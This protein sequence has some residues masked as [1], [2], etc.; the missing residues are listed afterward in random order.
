MGSTEKKWLVK[1]N[2]LINGPFE[3]NEVVENI[4][5]GDVHLLDEIKGPFERW[6]P[7]RDHSLFAAAIERL[8]A[9][10]YSRREVTITETVDLGTHAAD[11]TQ[12]STETHGD[13][14]TQTLT[15][16]GAGTMTTPASSINNRAK[17]QSTDVDVNIRN[18]IQAPRPIVK[19]QKSRF[20]LV[21]IATFMIIIIAAGAVLLNDF[22]QTKRVEVNTSNFD[23]YTDQGLIH[24]KVGQYREALSFFTKAYEIS[25]NDPNLILEMSPLLVQ[26]DGQFGQV[27]VMIENLLATQYQKEFMKRGKNI[28]GMSLS[29][30]G[31]YE[32]AIGEYDKSLNIDDQYYSALVNKGFALLKIGKG[33]DALPVLQKAIQVSPREA[34]ARYLLTRGLIQEGF[35]TKN[36]QYFSEALSTSNGHEQNFTDFRQEVLFL[37]AVAKMEIGVSKVDLAAAVRRFLSVDT[38]L[39]SLHVHN[40]EHDFQS[41]SWHDYSELC[42]G[43]AQ[44]LDQYTG[45]MLLGFCQ[46]KMDDVVAAK[47]TFEP[48]LS[49]KK[50]D[51]G[52][53]ALYVSS[54]FLLEDTA[55]AKNTINFVSKVDRVKPLVQSLVRGCLTFG[56]IEC[57]ES[58]MKSPYASKL[59]LLYS[60]WSLAEINIS[61]DKVKAKASV[62]QG[63]NIS[64]TFSPLL[65]LSREL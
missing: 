19:K 26:F 34:L 38:E 39:T 9:T 61:K 54:L 41:F 5:K 29:Y 18:N 11:L 44:K 15:E 52:L 36:K 10:T 12:T 47:S 7:I 58:I 43:L 16:T 59:S 42:K 23:D 56:D 3:F 37:A 17:S 1:S 13:D 14:S 33:K 28:V 40:V 48:L 57:V 53:Q 65:K 63:L 24:L 49:Q 64:P 4:F 21:F 45:S 32:D 50:S 60:H 51:G 25:P 27:Q 6:R 55:Q 22:K 35:R 2:D 62:R 20:P 30:R 46:L 31:Q 8:K